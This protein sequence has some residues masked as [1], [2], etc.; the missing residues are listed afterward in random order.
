[1]DYVGND[2]VTA[3]KR[4]IQECALFAMEEKAIKNLEVHFWTYN[5]NTKACKAKSL[6]IVRTRTDLLVS[7]SAECGQVLAP[8][9]GE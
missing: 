7:G 4:S 3:K 6:A 2:V 5:P 8:D 9:F 1:M